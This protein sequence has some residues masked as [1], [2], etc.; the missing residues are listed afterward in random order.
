MPS[1]AA[2]ASNTPANV[3]LMPPWVSTLSMRSIS[4]RLV[5]E[6]KSGVFTRIKPGLQRYRLILGLLV[7]GK[8]A[9]AR[10]LHSVSRRS[11]HGC[12]QMLLVPIENH[13]DSALVGLLQHLHH[14]L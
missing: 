13:D 11:D 4:D 10:L 14:I 6:F 12:D 9:I 7:E 2:L 1:S 3:S 8:R 5:A